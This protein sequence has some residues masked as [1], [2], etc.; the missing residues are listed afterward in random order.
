MHLEQAER[1]K[2]L[3]D[4]ARERKRGCASVILPDYS[5]VSYV[6]D[7]LE[8]TDFVPEGS[9]LSV[10]AESLCQ[11]LQLQLDKTSIEKGNS[12]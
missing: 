2:R 5:D 7:L 4:L 9:N 1:I 6:L 11:W 12:Q 3:Y 10:R 8:E